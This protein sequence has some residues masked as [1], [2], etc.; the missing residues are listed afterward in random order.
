MYTQ[1]K[2][3][4]VAAF[5]EGMLAKTQQLDKQKST[6]TNHVR[7]A[8]GCTHL[9]TQRQVKR[10]ENEIAFLEGRALDQALSTLQSTIDGLQQSL[11]AAEQVR[12]I[13]GCSAL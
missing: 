4:N 11:Q 13:H 10:L 2:V 1:M 8:A 5:Q 12:M 6:Y 9:L 3:K 7:T